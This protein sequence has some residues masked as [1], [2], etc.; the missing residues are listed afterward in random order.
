MKEQSLTRL[1]ANFSL[2]LGFAELLAPRQVARLA[3]INED[4]DMLIR[5]CGLREIA[6]GLGLMQGKPSIFLWSRVGG[7]AID[8]ALLGAAMR[9]GNNDRRRLNVAFAAVA[10]VTVLDVVASIMASRDHAEAGWRIQ[11]SDTYASGFERGDPAELRACC[12]D[13]MSAQSGHV[14]RDEA[15]EQDMQ[16]VA[17]VPGSHNDL[18][19]LAGLDDGLEETEAKAAVRT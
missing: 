19:A 14:Y 11:N 3:G 6:S 15:V 4:H 9:S 12:D 13:A 18:D 16:P 8:L 5:A 17:R 1:L 2:G 10:G 7:D